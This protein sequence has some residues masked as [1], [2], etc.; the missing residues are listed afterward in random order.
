MYNNTRVT[1][2][3]TDEDGKATYVVNAPDDDNDNDDQQVGDDHDND[4]D[5]PAVTVAANLE[6]RD[7][8]ITFTYKMV[9]D[10][11]GSAADAEIT[12]QWKEDNPVTT[13]AVSTA[14]AY[15]LPDKDGDLAIT[16]SV[17][18]YDQYGNGIREGGVGQ[19]AAIS[20]GSNTPADDGTDNVN[21]NRN[22]V[23]TRRVVIK[24]TTGPENNVPGTPIP[25]GF[26]ERPTVDDDD[27]DTTA[28]TGV[29]QDD[30]TAITGVGNPA[31]DQS[32]Q[33]VTRADD[34]DVGSVVVNAL[35]NDHD[36]FLANDGAT[37][38]TEGNSNL[39]YS[40]GSGDTFVNGVENGETEGELLTMEKF[41]DMLDDFETDGTRAMVDV[42]VYN[43]DG[44]SIF[45]VKVASAVT[46]PG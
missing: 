37:G 41:E 23:A 8:K 32:V 36:E 4:P 18:L 24:K 9:K 28:F 43:P 7:D 16:A 15:I 22:G 46:P 45:R 29:A 17:T 27:P 33:V 19:Q 25:V 5:T 10:R 26:E 39:V 11:A 30:V 40:Y 34:D 31:D 38:V 2:L 42:V 35:R 3:T 21:V 13:S 14:P 6:N 44:S 20:I 12:I 1:T